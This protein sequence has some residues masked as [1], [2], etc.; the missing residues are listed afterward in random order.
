M[1]SWED[2]LFRRSPTVRTSTIWSLVMTIRRRAKSN[3]TFWSVPR[4]ACRETAAAWFFYTCFWKETYKNGIIQSRV[5]DKNVTP[6]AFLM[7]RVFSFLLVLSLRAASYEWHI[8]VNVIAEHPPHGYDINPAQ[9]LRQHRTIKA[10]VLC[11]NF[12]SWLCC[13]FTVIH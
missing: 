3:R 8:P 10:A 7:P 2:F 13:D 1:T 12:V 9:K 5:T 11:G 6:E 4:R